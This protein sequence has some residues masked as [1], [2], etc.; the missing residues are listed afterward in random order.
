MI[1]LYPQSTFH[2]MPFPFATF[3]LSNTGLIINGAHY[4]LNGTLITS[5][6]NEL[7]KF[8][9]I[10]TNKKGYCVLIL[11]IPD[12]HCVFLHDVK[13]TWLWTQD[14][15]LDVISVPNTTAQPTEPVK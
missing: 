8:V 5:I 9:G 13:S 10:T 4:E 1:A 14:G 11:N 3:D 15:V 2:K 6:D 7:Y 12:E